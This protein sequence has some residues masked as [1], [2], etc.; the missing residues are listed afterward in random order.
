MSENFRYR[1]STFPAFALP[2]HSPSPALPAKGPVP[3]M[4]LARRAALRPLLGLARRL[5]TGPGPSQRVAVV[6]SGAVGLY[7]GSRLAEAGHTQ[8]GSCTSGVIKFGLRF[9]NFKGF[10]FFAFEGLPY[11]SPVRF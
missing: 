9:P 4:A 2:G 6:G 1:W 11:I 7:Y 5:S 3:S 10:L 8:A